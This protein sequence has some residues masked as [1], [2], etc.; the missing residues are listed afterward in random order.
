[1][2]NTIY[3]SKRFKLTEHCVKYIRK[4]LSIL[5]QNNI[6]YKIQKDIITKKKELEKKLCI[7]FKIS[8]KTVRDIWNYKTWS[9]VIY[10]Y[11]P[12]SLSISNF[13]YD[14]NNFLYDY[15][16]LYDEKY[17]LNDEKY[18]LHNKLYSDFRSELCKLDPFNYLWYNNKYFIKNHINTKK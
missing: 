9:K 11:I 6:E 17:F 14:E 3:I 4:S 15:D 8:P 7:K 2:I 12:Y 10:E 5:F 18:F 16:F 13:T 1:M